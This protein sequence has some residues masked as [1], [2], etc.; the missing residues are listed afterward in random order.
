MIAYARTYTPPTMWEI[1]PEHLEEAMR[2]AGINQSQLAERVGVKQPSIGRLLSGETKTTR[3]IEQIAAVLGTSPAYLKKG[4]THDASPTAAGEQQLA[5]RGPPIEPDPDLVK[6]DSIDLAFGLGGTFLDFDDVEVEKM[7]FSRTWLRKFT[8]S[9]PNLLFFSEGQGDSMTPTIH[10]R[11]VVIID[12]AKTDPADE[13]GERIWA[14]VFGG[15]GM[16]KRLRPMPDG[17]VKISSDNQLIR[18]EIA[19]DGDL[20]I[21]GRVVAIMKRA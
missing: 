17:T 18:D 16:L 10:D 21:I 8:P 9:P 19:S 14:C 7:T 12:R 3:A 13:V 11:D 5:W 4:G 1:D 20:H 15:M 6:I 2:R